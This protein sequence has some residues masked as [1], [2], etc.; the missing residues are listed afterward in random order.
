MHHHA[1]C[2]KVWQ[3]EKKEVQYETEHRCLFPLGVAIFGQWKAAQKDKSLR[4]SGQN[5]T[6]VQFLQE[7]VRAGYKKR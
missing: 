3:N 7:K 4:K 5:R 2:L 1:K 6:K